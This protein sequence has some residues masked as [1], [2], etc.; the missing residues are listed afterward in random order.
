MPTTT[1]KH[2]F[3]T[4]AAHSKEKFVSGIQEIISSY[5]WSQ[6]EA[7]RQLGITQP[8]LSNILNGNLQ[9]ISETKL[10]ACLARLGSCIHIIVSLPNETKCGGVSVEFRR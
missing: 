8:R 6:R 3:L 4:D 7:A 5:G 9:G 10:L 2:L 1:E